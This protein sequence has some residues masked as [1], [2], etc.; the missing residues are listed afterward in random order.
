MKK[1]ISKFLS[2]IM[3]AA[4][5]VTV[6]AG[7]SKAEGVSAAEGITVYVT[8]SVEG[9]LVLKQK[10]VEVTDINDD[11]ALTLTDAFVCAHAKYY[12]GDNTDSGF[13][14]GTGDWGTYVTKLWGNE[15]GNFS[16]YVNDIS[17][18]GLDDKVAGGDY[19]N[20]FVFIDGVAYSDKYTFFNSHKIGVRNGAS[21]TVKLSYAGFD[22]NWATVVSPLTNARI[23]INEKLTDYITNAKGK[24]TLEFDKAGSYF[25]SAVSQDGSIIV[26][27]SCLIFVQPKNGDTIT[28]KDIDYTVTKLGTV[29]TG[30]KGRVTFSKSANEGKTAP[31]T[32]DFAGVTYKVKVVD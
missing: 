25:V 6:S 3:I 11:G 17:S 5:I 31:K 7:F 9:D 22:E 2:M 26:P 28:V 27:P 23:V 1:T 20:A 30:K 4:M 19:I 21:K 12:T 15:S 32:V 10:S 29:K 24:V 13:A 18:M 16:Y 8:I 14:Y